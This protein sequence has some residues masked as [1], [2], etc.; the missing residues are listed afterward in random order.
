[1][2]HRSDITTDQITWIIFN[3]NKKVT[4]P[5]FDSEHLHSQ[6]DGNAN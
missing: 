1:M 2:N 5:G 6:G 3:K 4:H